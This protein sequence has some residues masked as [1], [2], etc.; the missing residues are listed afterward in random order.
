MEIS[1]RLIEK[2]KRNFDDV[3]FMSLI[4]IWFAILLFSSISEEKH[5]INEIILKEEIGIQRQAF[6]YFNW[7]DQ[8]Q[9]NI[10]NFAKTIKD[11]ES[12][13]VLD[14]NWNVVFSNPKDEI[15]SVHSSPYSASIINTKSWY[16]NKTWQLLALD[17][18]KSSNKIIVRKQ[19][20]NHYKKEII[21]QHFSILFL[22]IFL[23]TTIYISY[24]TF[25]I[26]RLIIS[27]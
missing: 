18:N 20:S 25:F 24:N 6:D 22:V 27:K 13:I 16:N 11:V 10:I 15:E 19:L 8:N 7:K 26:K 23:I 2:I 14:I 3:S 9:A 21:T 17:F 12:I 4:F 5:K 1:S